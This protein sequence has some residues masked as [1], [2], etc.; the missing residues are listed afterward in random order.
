[1]NRK[2]KKDTLGSESKANQHVQAHS[3]SAADWTLK[4]TLEWIIER[5]SGHEVGAVLLFRIDRVSITRTELPGSKIREHKKEANCDRC[6]APWAATTLE[7]PTTPRRNGP[8]EQPGCGTQWISS[9]SSISK[10]KYK[11]KR[12]REIHVRRWQVD[13][14]EKSDPQI[15]NLIKCSKQLFLDRFR[16]TVVSHSTET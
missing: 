7:A 10:L 12:E 14:V 15:T 6:R 5:R 9:D 16:S 13:L 8:R 1:M 3:C 4:W 11:R 2:N